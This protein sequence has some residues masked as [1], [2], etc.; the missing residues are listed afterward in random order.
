DFNDAEVVN[1]AEVY[2]TLAD[3]DKAREYA[4]R[5]YQSAWADGPPYVWWWYLE[6]AKAVLDALGE[7]YP[8]LPPFDPAKIGQYPYQDEIEAHIEAKRQAREG[9]GE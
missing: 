7:P 3:H 1:A 8:A 2:L 9:D 4:I 6:R 5:G